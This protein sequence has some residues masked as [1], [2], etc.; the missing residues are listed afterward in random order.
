M[1]I[2]EIKKPLVNSLRLSGFLLFAVLLLYQLIRWYLYASQE[3][4]PVPAVAFDQ[5]SYLTQV[6][7]A[8]FIGQAQGLWAAI[9][10]FFQTVPAQGFLFQ[11]A[12][13]MGLQILPFGRASALLINVILYIGLCTILLMAF[14]PKARFGF[15]A[16]LLAYLFSL[17]TLYRLSGGLMDFRLDFAGLCILTC[18]CLVI[19]RSYFFT[20]SR[21][22]VLTGTLLVVLCCT[23]FIMVVEMA[24]VLLV[25]LTLL[26]IIFLV[27]RPWLVQAHLQPIKILQGL[28]VT[29]GVAALGIMP[30]LL[31]FWRSL[32]A[33]YIGGHVQGDEPGIRMTE[34]GVHNLKESLLFYPYEMLAGQLGTI[35]TILL[36]AVWLAAGVLL[37]RARQQPAFT[38]AISK[39]QILWAVCFILAL[40]LGLYFALTLD[41]AKSVVTANVFLVPIT[42]LYIMGLYICTHA[43]AAIGNIRYHRIWWGIGT[44]LLVAVLVLQAGRLFHTPFKHLQPKY[45]AGRNQLVEILAGT[46]QQHHWQHPRLFVNHNGD[47]DAAALNFT[48]LER[49]QQNL[50]LQAVLTQIFAVKPEE[51]WPQLAAAHF[52]VMIQPPPNSKKAVY[53]YDRQMTDLAP[54]LAEFCRKNGTLLFAY[55]YYDYHITLYA[56]RLVPDGY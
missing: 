39:G 22:C 5:I 9:I 24:S 20:R 40:W 12:A 43:L 1:K 29:I 6:Y 50:G 10:G 33:Y 30:Y 8:Y 14:K 17:K 52:I 3:I 15:A 7:N 28:G 18:T 35:S 16:L 31:I 51:L 19:W 13:F 47:H 49:L 46:S 41:T 4:V 37:W 36:G 11:L 45:V 38:A 44:I 23:R 48:A 56:N 54:Q 42:A 32:S 34:A 2:A 21:Y 53:P 26:A 55:Q 25:F 27:K